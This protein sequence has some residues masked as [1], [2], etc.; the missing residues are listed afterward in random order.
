MGGALTFEVISAECIPKYAH[1]VYI[2]MA[3]AAKN[4]TSRSRPFAAGTGALW[5][6]SA[7]GVVAA[8]DGIGRTWGC[9]TAV[10]FCK[11]RQGR[12]LIPEC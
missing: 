7:K 9:A 6:I 4:G 12:I 11:V 3:T 8:C 2:M 1:G 10:P 5:L